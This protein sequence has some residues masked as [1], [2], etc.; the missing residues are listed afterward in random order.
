MATLTVQQIANTGLEPTYA[1][2]SAGGDVFEFTAD[3]F[4]HVKNGDASSHTVSVV[5]QYS[6]T[7]GIAPADIDV[8][9]PSGEERMIGPFKRDFFENSAT[10]EVELTYDAVTSVTIAAL[11][12]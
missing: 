1:A 7:P 4:I 5:S 10:G 8:A 12:L 6:A 9:I 3:A 2:A 11:R